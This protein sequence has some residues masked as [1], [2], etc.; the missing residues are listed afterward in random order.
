MAILTRQSCMRARQREF[1]A[2][3]IKFSILPIGGGMAGGT[4]GSILSIM[5]VILFVTGIAVHRRACE[6][7]ICMTRLTRDSLVFSL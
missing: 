2:I 7:S 4:I 6:L 5:L 1:A 3:M